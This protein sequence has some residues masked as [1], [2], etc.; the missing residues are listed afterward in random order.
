M[1]GLTWYPAPE[2]AE[3]AKRVAATFSER[4][5]GEP[6]GVW[7][8]PGR[9]NLIG[10]HIDYSGGPCLP[11]ALPHRTFVALRRRGDED[12]RLHS[13]QG[14]AGD[15]EWSGPL[16]GVRPG[17]IHGWAAYAAG[18]AWALAQDGL[19]APG[20]EASVDGWVP[21]GSGLSSSA[22][23]ECAVAVALDE[24]AGLGLGADDEGRRRLAALCVR[25]ENEIAGAPTGGM[26]QAASLRTAAGAALL[27][28]C[29]DFSARQVPFDLAAAGL[30][31]LVIDTRTSHSH[32][33]GQYGQRRAT[34]E[35]AAELLGV[36][37]LVDLT[38]RTDVLEQLPD[39][40]ARRRVRHVLTEIDRVHQAAGLLR[41]KRFAELGPVLDASHASLRDDY[42]VSCAE[43]DVACQSAR[44]AGALGARMTGGGFGGCA[45]ALVAADGVDAV[46][47]AVAAAF[48]A[49][50]WRPP[51]FLLGEAAGPASR[52]A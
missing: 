31:L 50:D 7:A 29:R 33:G 52:V 16:S 47:Q 41:E 11:F 40:E 43:L 17:S 45:I 30:A 21:L 14:P 9:A 5:G 13:A 15:T 32:A 4:F 10:E 3:A 22:A 48:A 28:D 49:Q 12:L 36:E 1:S 46:A 42:E 8:A 37:Q 23:L 39:P 51:A 34:C 38:G 18:V 27:L 25:A 44:A 19:P 24:V 2:P 26:D 20:F 6:E 35:Q